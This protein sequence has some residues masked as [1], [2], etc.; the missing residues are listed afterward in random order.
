MRDIPIGL[1]AT[2]AYDL[3]TGETIILPSSVLWSYLRELPL[4]A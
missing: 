3:P 4:P 2:T 1:A